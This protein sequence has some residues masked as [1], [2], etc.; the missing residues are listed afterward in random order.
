MLN[1]VPPPYP[2]RCLP[3]LMFGAGHDVC[4]RTQTAVA[5]VA[6][7]LIG[8]ASLA[9][10][11]R[12]KVRLP[13][14]KV[15][16]TALYLLIIAESGSGKSACE[17]LIYESIRKLDAAK[18]VLTK[19]LL[20]AHRAAK[21]AWS[22]RT[23]ALLGS[24]KRSATDSDEYVSL[25]A[26]LAK[27]IAH[28]PT[29]PQ[30]QRLLYDDV[31][32]QALLRAMALSGNSA[33][34]VSD[35]AGRQLFGGAFNDAATFSQIWD[36]KSLT[37]DRVSSEPLDITD[38]KLTVGVAVQPALFDKA[39]ADKAATLRYSGLLARFMISRPIST[40]GYRFL[41]N[42]VH[43][44]S[45]NLDRFKSRLDELLASRRSSP[46][47]EVPILELSPGAQREWFDFHNEV[48]GLQQPGRM[49]EEIKDA[50]S[51]ASDQAA[52][53]AAIFHQ[54]ETDEGPVAEHCMI[55][56]AHIVR[57]HLD[58]FNRLLSPGFAPPQ[59]QVDAEVLFDWLR[60]IQPSVHGPSSCP[61]S[62]IQQY[63]PR[64]LRC[65]TRIREA[66]NFLIATQ[67]AHMFFVGKQ[68]WL[69]LG[70]NW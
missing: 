67:R 38:P 51:R 58:E 13:N 15:S 66:I 39:L 19:E 31:S 9:C 29:P 34:L 37:V 53:L 63:G 56:A 10:Q 70:R 21:M 65:R 7:T 61:V 44:D 27:H 43:L 60:A 30:V 41:D 59:H 16:P 25:T 33:A 20:S 3:Q 48:E 55:N 8:A 57:W 69:R 1:F 36:G 12:F 2:E 24:I 45:P 23:D 11:H 4:V 46:L 22:I 49:Y 26:E 17:V 32:P 62:K 35:E 68:R 42:S 6:S 5:M 40:Q 52:R 54:L 18:K 64:P 28:E 50:A 14:K 47:A